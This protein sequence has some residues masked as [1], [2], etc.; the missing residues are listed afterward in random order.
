MQRRNRK[1]QSVYKIGRR[2]QSI[3]KYINDDMKYLK[4]N[5]VEE[6]F[7]NFPESKHFEVAEGINAID[8]KAFEDLENLES[9]SLPSSLRYI[10]FQAF[11]NCRNL[12]SITIPEIEKIERDAFENC[13]NLYNVKIDSNRYDF[14]CNCLFEKNRYLIFALPDEN[15]IVNIPNNIR[16]ISD[17]NFPDNIKE[18]RFED[19][20]KLRNIEITKDS[21]NPALQ[22]WIKYLAKKDKLNEIKKAAVA[23]II[24]KSLT[25]EQLLKIHYEIKDD[26]VYITYDLKKDIKGLLYG[27]GTELNIKILFEEF[28]KVTS[29]FF[30]IL[31]KYKELYNEN[32]ILTEKETEL[33]EF[34]MKTCNIKI[35]KVSIT[36]WI[37]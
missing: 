21:K 19:E 28:T 34:I 25:N 8:D 22:K 23:A 33:K 11:R 30:N 1:R 32:Y 13:I 5:D 12:K 18:I 26:F 37:S 2:R 6:Y 29:D 15:G 35:E 17:F 14:K 20:T 36:S 31:F 9:V 4:R 10:S 16:T 7:L 27:C 24:R 3:Y